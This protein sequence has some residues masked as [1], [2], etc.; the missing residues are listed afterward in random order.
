MGKIAI[1]QIL[2]NILLI[3]LFL[4]FQSEFNSILNSK[5]RFVIKYN[6]PSDDPDDPF[7]GKRAVTQL[8]KKYNFITYEFTGKTEADDKILTFFR[9]EAV[10][11]AY[12]KDRKNV[13]RIYIPEVLT[14]GR[15]VQLLSLMKE[16]GHR[17][18][19]EWGNYFYVVGKEISVD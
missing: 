12:I 5:N 1:L 16:D 19:F 17:R 4:L 7:N 11:L 14:Y 18:Y 15:F 10:R 2:N 9:Y 6:I 13:L 8:K 3:L